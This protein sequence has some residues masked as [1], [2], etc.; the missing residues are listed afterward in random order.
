MDRDA[1]NQC[2]NLIEVI[3]QEIRKGIDKEFTEYKNK[4][5]EELEYKIESNR[6]ECVKRVLDGIDVLLSADNPMSLE[7]NIM[8]RIEKKVVLK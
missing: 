7:P 6:N 2:N 1:I 8:I 5:L 4:C 3:K